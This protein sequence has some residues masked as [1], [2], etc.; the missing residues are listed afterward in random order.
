MG[1]HNL[2]SL[3]REKAI[4]YGFSSLTDEELLAIII[5][6]GSKNENVISL[7]RRLLR[8]FNGIALLRYCTLSDLCSIKG[9]KS[10]KALNL[11]AVFEI[12]KR[13]NK[14]TSEIVKTDEDAFKYIYP[15]FD[16]FDQECFYAMFLSSRN[17]VI[18]VRLIAKGN[19]SHI[20]IDDNDIIRECLKVNS[21][22]I[23]IF[24]NHPSGDLYPSLDD[25]IKTE[26]LKIKCQRMNLNLIDHLIIGF[27][28]F[29]SM[30]AHKML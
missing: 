22:N 14:N 21:R 29:Y 27:N 25:K 17:K 26:N 28:D 3:P 15:L 11:M 8:T 13:M 16:T 12:A 24:H 2:E 9:L 18:A 30:K 23:I 1:K 6:T 5:R 10:A 20:E 4:K 19:I 7:S